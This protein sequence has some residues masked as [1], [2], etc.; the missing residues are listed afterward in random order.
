V[1]VDLLSIP[2]DS[3]MRGARMGAGPDALLAAGLASR[4]TAS[5]HEVSDTAIELPESG[6][7]PEAQAAFALD[8][9]LA[10]TVSACIARGAF[11]MVLSGNCISCIGTV[12][13]IGDPA[14]GAIWFDAHGDF[15]TPET[16]RSGFLDGMS[17]GTLTGRCWRALAGNHSVHCRNV[18]RACRSAHGI[19]PRTG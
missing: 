15:N 19:R 14:L 7:F 10:R 3:G 4:L 11:P 6:F 2:Y 9:S 12:G 18:S 13:G 17:L 16:T 8:R 5:G 1:R